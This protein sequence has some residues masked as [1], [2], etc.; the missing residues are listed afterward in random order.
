MLKSLNCRKSWE[1]YRYKAY[2]VAAGNVVGTNEEALRKRDQTDSTSLK[3]KRKQKEKKSKKI[4][5]K[6]TNYPVPNVSLQDL[7]EPLPLPHCFIEDK[8]NNSEDEQR[9][10]DSESETCDYFGLES[11]SNS[12]SDEEK[13]SESS[14]N[15]YASLSNNTYS[16]DNISFRPS[17]DEKNSQD[18]LTTYTCGKCNRRGHVTEHC[19]LTCSG[20]ENS[21]TQNSIS[22]NVRQL[23]SECRKLR[24]S[25]NHSCVDCGNVSNL[26]FCFECRLSL[27]DGRG[28]LIEHLLCNPTHN[29]LY[30]FKLQKLLKCS[31]SSCNTVDISQLLVCPQCLSKIFDKHYSLVNATWSNKALRAITNSL[32]CEIHFQWHRMNCYASSEELMFSR[33][34]LL[35]LKHEQNGLLSEF[36]F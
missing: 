15:R 7:T 3:R 27:C 10:E 9:C 30:S 32:C 1:I 16:N 5:D 20:V 26:A 31:N 24:S 6:E 19:T 35:K 36:F 22:S 28:H 4:K 8:A 34:N 25:Q 14:V 17:C 13:C 18:F 33:E 29:K 23:F 11:N 21:S 12:S 2:K